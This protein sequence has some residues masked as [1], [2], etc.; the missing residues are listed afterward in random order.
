MLET[1]RLI[2]QTHEPKDFC[3][4][5]GVMSGPVKRAQTEA[6]YCKFREKLSS[7]K[8]KYQYEQFKRTKCQKRHFKKNKVLIL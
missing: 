1:C 3:R 2:L 6:N 5:N 4:V 8:V 7:K